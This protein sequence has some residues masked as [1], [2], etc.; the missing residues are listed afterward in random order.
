MHANLATPEH[1]GHPPADAVPSPYTLPALPYEIDALEPYISGRTIALHHDKH[2]A[3][4]VAGANL[5]LA[6]L[7]DARAS[8]QF[9][10]VEALER[11]YAFNLSGHV[12]HSLYWSNLKPG[13][14][15]EPKGALAAAIARDF[16]SFD[17]FHKQLVRCASTIPGAGWAMLAWEP[18]AGR[19]ITLQLHDHQSETVQGCSPLLVLDAWEHAYYL[20]HGPDKAAYFAAIWNLWNWDD[21]A[22]RLEIASLRSNQ[23]EL[24]PPRLTPS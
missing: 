7:A 22:Q 1:N 11:L 13:S 24:A 21:V 23:P 3:A 5:A 10:R 15:G 8:G 16:G 18:L 20:Q 9:E 2:H 6:Q 4:Y 17:A 12:L 19:L 14:G